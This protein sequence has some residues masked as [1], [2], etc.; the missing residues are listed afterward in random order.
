MICACV[1]VNFGFVKQSGLWCGISILR[2]VV[3]RLAALQATARALPHGVLPKDR[4]Y[5]S[6]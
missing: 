2:E 1:D 4:E 6:Q 5:S 3:A